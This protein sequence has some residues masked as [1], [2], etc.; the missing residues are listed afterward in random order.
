[1]FPLP[2]VNDPFGIEIRF[3]SLGFAINLTD[4]NRHLVN[5]KGTFNYSGL[6]LRGERI[7]SSDIKIDH[8][9]SSFLAHIGQDYVEFDSATRVELNRI[10]LKPYLRF[11]LKNDPVITIKILPVNWDADD[12]FSSLPEGMFTSLTGIKTK[13]SLNY[14]LSFSANLSNPDSLT[15]DTRLT[16]RDFN[17]IAY[18][19]DDYRLINGSFYHQVYEHGQVKA[20]FLVG[21]ENPDFVPFNQISPWLRASV[22]TSEDGVFSIIMVSTP[23]HSGNP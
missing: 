11:G 7:S 9:R 6:G 17:I 15:F 21:P 14:H 12:F 13:G 20:A 18:G 23:G 4:R 5:M 8:F 16:A 2:V 10:S 22:M 3:D 1:M 19:T